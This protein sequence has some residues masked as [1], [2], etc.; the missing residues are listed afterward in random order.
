MPTAL[1]LEQVALPGERI[2]AGLSAR[3]ARR[4]LYRIGAARFRDKVLLQWAA[5]PGP[6]ARCPG[7]CCC[8]WR[9][10]GS[11]RVFRSPAVMS[12]EAGVAEGPEVGRILGQVEDWWIGPG[13]RGRSR[14]LPRPAE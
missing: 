5:R 4:L 3:D 7:A 10:A 12:M 9:K 13:F 14:R 2:A 8:R 1:R 6:P 11:G